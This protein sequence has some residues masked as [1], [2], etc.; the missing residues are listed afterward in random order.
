MFIS[1]YKA[2]A[3]LHLAEILDIDLKGRPRPL[4]VRVLYVAR[5]QAAETYCLI[6]VELVKADS[7]MST[8]SSEPRFSG[9]RK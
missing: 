3:R 6:L 4:L 2:V 7:E 9:R 1:R 5:D 8:Q